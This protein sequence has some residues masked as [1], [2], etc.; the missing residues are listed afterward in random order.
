MEW[1]TATT[2]APH[3]FGRSVVPLSESRRYESWCGL[4][5][6]YRPPL[7]LLP[8]LAAHR[9]DLGRPGPV[10]VLPFEFGPLWDGHGLRCPFP[11]ASYSLG[12]SQSS[13]KR[14]CG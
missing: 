11:V 6:G 13:Q 4:V 9:K 7:F 1:G 12:L 3:L 8:K 14:L 5:L 10:P 2:T